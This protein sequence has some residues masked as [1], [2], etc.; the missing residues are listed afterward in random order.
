MAQWW[1]ACPAC[2]KSSWVPSSQQDKIKSPWHGKV[3]CGPA[4]QK[5]GTPGALCTKPR[6][7]LKAVSLDSFSGESEWLRKT[8]AGGFC[9]HWCQLERPWHQRS[10]FKSVELPWFHNCTVLG[11]LQQDTTQRTPNVGLNLWNKKP[12]SHPNPASHLLYVGQPRREEKPRKGFPG[13]KMPLPDT[14]TH[15]H[16]SLSRGSLLAPRWN[17]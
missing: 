5:R 2:G 16:S 17:G 14:Y 11:S 6:T 4:A 10:W 13:S 12:S 8:E 15:G 9:A 1:N 3:W 7:H